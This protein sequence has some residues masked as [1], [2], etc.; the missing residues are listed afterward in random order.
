MSAMDGYKKF[1]TSV[2]PN[3]KDKLAKLKSGQAPYTFLITCSDSRI[4]PNHMTSTEFGE[5][6]VVRNAGNTVSGAGEQRGDADAATLEYAVKALG[7]KEVIVCGHTHC[8]A[9][10]ALLTGV[11]KKELPLIADYLDRLEPLRVKAIE[12]NLVGNEAI[13]ENVRMQMSNV[14]S[15]DFVADAVKAGILKVEGWLYHI[16]SGE[17]ELVSSDGGL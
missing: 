10:G 2:V 14:L 11:D 5:L 6:F 16:E 8:G 12:H 7:V 9:V 17:V 15:H 4:C 3:I 1:Q 13:K